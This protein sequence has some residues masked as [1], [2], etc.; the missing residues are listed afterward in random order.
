MLRSAALVVLFSLSAVVARASTSE[1]LTLRNSQGSGVIQFQLASS[2]ILLAENDTKEVSKNVTVTTA[3]SEHNYMLTIAANMGGGA[4]VGFLLGGAIY[5][6]QEPGE[7]K[8]VNLAWW[9]G[10]GVIVGAVAGVVQVAVTANRDTKAV[11]DRDDNQALDGP[12][13]LAWG[14]KF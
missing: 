12:R 8:G 6:I 1:P 3:P 13:V 5:L 11:T 14:T 9:T 10:G 4:I 7:R 2:T